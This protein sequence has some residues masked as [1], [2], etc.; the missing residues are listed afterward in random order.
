MKF[1]YDFF[2]ILLFFI[3]YKFY[4]IYVA[5]AVAIVAS[6]VQVGWFWIRHRRIERMHLITLALITILGGA[7]LLLHDATFIKWKP[8]V[9]NWAFG[10]VLLGSQFIGKKP[11]VQR[12]METN[13]KLTTDHIW[14]RLNLSWVIFFI[15]LG[16]INL[17]V[18]F[19]FDE[20]TWV[21]FKLFGMFGI[22]FLFVI[23]QS[24]YLM[25]YMVPESESDEVENLKP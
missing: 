11:I 6:F 10:L 2:P 9:V 15:A 13:I 12:M 20:N 18:A 14:T 7:T 16:F 3:S 24:M 21:N 8:T 17:Y 25:R 1:L 22:T 5:T 23:A 19:N 4:D